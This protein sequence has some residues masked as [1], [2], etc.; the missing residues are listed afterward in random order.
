M[1]AKRLNP[2]QPSTS[3]WDDSFTAGGS[4]GRIVFP[5]AVP[6]YADPMV[7]IIRQS[8]DNVSGL[9][10]LPS[11]PTYWDATAIQLTMAGAAGGTT[12]VDQKFGLTPFSSAACTTSITEPYFWGSATDRKSVV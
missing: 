10:L 2:F 7:P 11:F 1:D 9:S 5:S 8:E 6:P 12:W 3:P 4:R